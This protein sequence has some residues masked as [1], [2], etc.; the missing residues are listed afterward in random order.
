MRPS[1]LVGLVWTEIIGYAAEDKETPLETRD[2]VG[3]GRW[4]VARDHMEV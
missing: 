4:S 1:E 2:G 3:S